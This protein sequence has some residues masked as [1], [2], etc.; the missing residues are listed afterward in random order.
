[1]EKQTI[2]IADQEI[3]NRLATRKHFL[4]D[5]ELL[6]NWK[7][8]DKFLDTI[9]IRRTSVAGRDAFSAEVMFRIM[10]LQSWYK[11]SDYQVE[12]QLGE[13]VSS[14]LDNLSITLV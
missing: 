13:F 4:K 11:L 14:L 2:T 12:V 5:I 7:R 1:M 8:I 10:L 3:F 9:E 6:I